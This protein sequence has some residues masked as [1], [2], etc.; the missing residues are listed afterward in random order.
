MLRRQQQKLSVFNNIVL[1]IHYLLI[2]ALLLAIVAKYIS[3]DLFW[4]PSFFGLAFPFL[5]LLNLIFSVY[6]LLQLK[7]V[8]LF[9]LGALLLG[10]PTASRY[11]QWQLLDR[12]PE[13]K[14]FRVT[15][16]NSMLFDLYNWKKNHESRH[17][18][19]SELNDISPDILCVQE[20]YTSEDRND[21]NNLDTV[22]R[23]LNTPYVHY[24]YTATLR[25]NDHWGMATFS[26]FPIVNQGK[27]VFP[28]KSNNLCIFSDIVINKDTIRIYNVHLQ[29]ISFS[30]E[31]EK[32]RDEV[33]SEAD[34][35]NEVAK[36]KNILRRLKRAFIKR[37][38]QAEMI[39]LHM[40]TCPYKIILCGDFN[41][42]AASYVY[43]KLTRDLEDAFM[44]KGSGL[45]RTYAGDWPQFRI[46]YILF[47]KGIH[48]AE[49]K[50]HDE[51]FTDHHPVSASFEKK[52]LKN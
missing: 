18:I 5:F 6:W 49:Y 25:Q 17:K 42:T 23:L 39:A 10:L 24:E 43:E 46:D 47:G 1:W 32:F 45:G 41:D 48:C 14:L 19:L 4:L 15:S 50:R 35:Q 30:R 51:T 7:Y 21:F 44:V 52:N 31:D 27:I 2:L 11:L 29:S 33:I 8:A 16:Y 13:A 40:S 26:R 34:A 38:R 20:F 12:K 36:S 22:K 3:P 28:T 37:S 9:G